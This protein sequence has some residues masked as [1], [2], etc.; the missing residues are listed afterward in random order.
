MGNVSVA[1]AIPNVFG[2]G[3]G[4]ERWGESNVVVRDITMSNSYATGG[5]TLPLAPLGLTRVDLMIPAGL[6]SAKTV[7]ATLL[8]IGGSAASAPKIQAF[9]GGSPPINVYDEGNIKGSA[10]TNVINGAAPTNSAL[11]ANLA[12]ANNTTPLTIALQPDVG[13]NICVAIKNNTGG[14]A[15][16]N[17]STYTLVGTFQGAAQTDTI[18]FSGADLNAMTN[19]NLTTKYSAKPFDTITS[20]TPGT[21]QPA[22]FQHS[23]GPGS[24]I[25]L[26]ITPFPNVEASLIKL[27]KNAADLSPVGTYSA[28]NVTVNFGTL[29][30]GDHISAEYKVQTAETEAAAGQDLSTVTQRVM[31]I[32]S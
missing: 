3:A 24:A 21:A 20:I 11:I 27:T 1:A 12:A 22:N 31:F 5:D 10:N 26:P 29:T 2:N 28:A 23:A 8:L 19:G 30:D 25:G 32:G 16:G 14:G 18:A 17:A 4:L 7:A 6:P 13:R 15:S 9:V